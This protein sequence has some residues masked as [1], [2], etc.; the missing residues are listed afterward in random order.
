MPLQV[1]NGDLVQFADDT[2]I[3]CSSKTHDEEI[4]EMLAICSNLCSLYLYIFLD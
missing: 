4:S 2:C 1:K 3:I